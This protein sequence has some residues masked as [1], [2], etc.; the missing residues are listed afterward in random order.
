MLISEVRNLIGHRLL[1]QPSVFSST[2][3]E[4]IF[5][6]VSLKGNIKETYPSHPGSFIWRFPE[7]IAPYILVEDLDSKAQISKS[8]PLEESI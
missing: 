7:N 2:L 1:I 4:V 5:S 8:S 3:V 6:E